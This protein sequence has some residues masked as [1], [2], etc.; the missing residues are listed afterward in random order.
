M[1][2][3]RTIGRVSRRIAAAVVALALSGAACGDWDVD[4]WAIFLEGHGCSGD[5]SQDFHVYG[6]GIDHW[7]P[8]TCPIQIQGPNYPVGSSGTVY[9]GGRQDFLFME[10]Q[11]TSYSGRPAGA[12][13]AEIIPDDEAPPD[14][15]IAFGEYNFWYSA[16][17]DDYCMDFMDWRF[18]QWAY[19]NPSVT[20]PY[21]H[22]VLTYEHTAGWSS[23]G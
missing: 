1:S 22:A 16:D 9:D 4:Y 14:S 5:S 20:L 10:I 13:F 15:P 21:L 2:N 12:G 23:C 6:V 17:I 8:R 11:V 19:P 18:T 3:T 7:E